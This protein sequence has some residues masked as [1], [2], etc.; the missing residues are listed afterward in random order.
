MAKRKAPG[1]ARLAVAPM[2]AEVNIF[3]DFLNSKNQV[4]ERHNQ[5]I[6]YRILPTQSWQPQQL[7]RDDHYVILPLDSKDK[8]SSVRMGFLNFPTG[9]TYNVNPQDPYGRAQ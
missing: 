8:I 1:A 4:I 5:P 6:C 9:Q 2:P 3:V 7:I